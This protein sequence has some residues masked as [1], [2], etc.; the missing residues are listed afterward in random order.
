MKQVKRFLILVIFSVSTLFSSQ[1]IERELAN[2]VERVAHGLFAG[3]PIEK[4]EIRGIFSEIEEIDKIKKRL[5]DHERDSDTSHDSHQSAASD[6]SISSVDYHEAIDGMDKIMDACFEQRENSPLQI[7]Q[8]K[9][10]IDMLY[11]F[12]SSVPSEIMTKAILM[13]SERLIY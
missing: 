1:A 4:Y 9:N 5:S 11:S 7:V 12:E 2:N 8:R 3:C 10:F 6:D 13:I